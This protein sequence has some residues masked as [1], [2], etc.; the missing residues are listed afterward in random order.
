MHWRAEARLDPGTVLAA[1][2]AQRDQ[3]VAD[4]LAVAARPA[5]KGAESARLA[6]VERLLG[7]P[8]LVDEVWV[9]ATPNCYARLGTAAGHLPVGRRPRLAV[10]ATVDDLDTVAALHGRAPARRRGGRMIGAGVN[11]TC[12]DATVLAVLRMARTLGWRPRGEVLVAFV[13]GEETGLTGARELVGRYAASLDGFIDVMG[14]V[15]T[16]SFNAIGIRHLTVRISGLSRHSLGGG[17]S[18]VP[19][20]LARLAQR[21]AARA[22]TPPLDG[23]RVLRVN[24]IHAGEVYNH[25]PAGGELWVDVRATD[26]RWL[27]DAVATV[28][29]EAGVVA[30]ETGVLAQVD[31]VHEQPAATLPGGATHPL[32]RAA[33][34]AM[35][36]IHDQPVTQRAWSSSN[37]NAAL[38]AGLPGVAL[39]GTER[40][41]GRGTI[42]EWCDLTGAVT[43]SAA[44]L[45]LLDSLC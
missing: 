38:A 40:G 2:W 41:G 36:A 44:L 43:G 29:A 34:R 23:H 27:D 6:V 19:D 16:V 30:A 7:E 10:V 9:D 45:L 22:P 37:V 3:M 14:G 42:E 33:V 11:T 1:A 17:V 39:E 8:G 12:G 4:W 20:A 5:P 26:Q 13:T 28:R 21:L 32:V 31:V 25:S 18:A 35:A 24:G 15:G